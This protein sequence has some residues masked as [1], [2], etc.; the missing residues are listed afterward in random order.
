MGID[1]TRPGFC[2]CSQRGW[3]G[4]NVQGGDRSRA[5]GVLQLQ[6]VEVGVL[7]GW[8][9]VGG[10]GWTARTLSLT[11][12]THKPSPSYSLQGL[13]TQKHEHTY[14]Q[15]PTHTHTNTDMPTPI[16]ASTPHRHNSHPPTHAHTPGWPPSACTP[17][18]SPAASAL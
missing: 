2:A 18:Q 6:A 12:C 15:P 10:L 3:G 11:H 9:G 5:A 4:V 8:S 7:W 17:C 1:T 13:S 16:P 14:S